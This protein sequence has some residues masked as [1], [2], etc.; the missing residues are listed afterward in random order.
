MTSKT[1]ITIQLAEPKFPVVM[2]ASS[3]L[4]VD[5]DVAINVHDLDGANT[6]RLGSWTERCFGANCSYPVA[7]RTLRPRN[8]KRC[9]WTDKR[10]R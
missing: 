10:S 9:H 5:R 3:H 8:R 2:V 7:T 1:P 4:T 6:T